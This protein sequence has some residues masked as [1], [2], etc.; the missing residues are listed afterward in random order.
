MDTS[1]GKN[2]AASCG[3]RSGGN[4]VNV[5][6]SVIG[7]VI[8]QECRWSKKGVDLIYLS[9]LRELANVKKTTKNKKKRK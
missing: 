1:L 2:V 7:S 8:G 5:V 3:Y 4:V 9:T 6:M